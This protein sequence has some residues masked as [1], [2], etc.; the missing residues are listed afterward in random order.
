M[1]NHLKP[2]FDILLPELEK[3]DINYW[4]YGGVAVAAFKGKFFRKNADVDVFV[5]KNDFEKAKRILDDLSL[6]AL[7]LKDCQP[8]TREGYD[9][10]KLNIKINRRERMSIVPVYFK[11]DIAK[12]IF[13]NG[14]KVYPVSILSRVKRSISGYNF[15]TPPNDVVKKIFI[16]SLDSKRSNKKVVKDA[17]A[18]LTS[19]EVAR[20]K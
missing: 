3:N 19:E 18:I 11:D 10:P 5:K 12:L 20:I 13:E 9:R 6:P 14:V 15:F 8:L 2:V 7:T 16:D 17:F 1:N 4:V